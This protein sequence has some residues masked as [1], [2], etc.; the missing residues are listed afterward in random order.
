MGFR[1][2]YQ[3]SVSVVTDSF[4]QMRVAVVFSKWVTL[5]IRFKGHA[6]IVVRYSY[7]NTKHYRGS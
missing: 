1:S 3:P 5:H 2:Y 6:V 4:R 7:P